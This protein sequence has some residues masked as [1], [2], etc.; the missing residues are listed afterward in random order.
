MN[1]SICDNTVSVMSLNEHEM[2]GDCLIDIKMSVPRFDISN[3]RQWQTPRS[4]CK[5]GI[6]SG[7]IDER[8][9]SHGHIGITQLELILLL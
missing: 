4:N 9:R 8:M 6:L 5:K 7:I 2:W 1:I 3:T